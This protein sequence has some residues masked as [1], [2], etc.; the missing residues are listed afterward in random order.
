MLPEGVAAGLATRTCHRVSA[1]QF[2]KISRHHSRTA[3]VSGR[4]ALMYG[5]VGWKER[6]SIVVRAGM[7]ESRMGRMWW[8][9]MAVAFPDR[10]VWK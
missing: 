7:S 8:V 5:F 4:V 1:R 3:G 10:Q 2:W 9:D 6:A